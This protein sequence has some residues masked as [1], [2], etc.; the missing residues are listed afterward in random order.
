MNLATF[1]FEATTDDIEKTDL[2]AFR[3]AF[4]L[5][6]RVHLFDVS[7]ALMAKCCLHKSLE[8]AFP[9]K[10]QGDT[11]GLASLDCHDVRMAKRCACHLDEELIWSW[12]RDGNIF[13]DHL[14]LRLRIKALAECDVYK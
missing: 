4:V 8:C 7:S 14:F 10:S 12:F 11:C 2:V 13:D 6:R 9:T 3:V 1:T 5:D